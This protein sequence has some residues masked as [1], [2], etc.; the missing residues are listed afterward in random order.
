[1]GFAAYFDASGGLSDSA[2]VVAGYIARVEDWE[3]FDADWRLVLANANVPYFHMKEF[4]HFKGPYSGWQ[5]QDTRRANFLSRLVS[6]AKDHLRCRITS[7]VVTEDFNAVDR[8]YMLSEG[9]EGIHALAAKTCARKARLWL[10]ANNYHEPLKLVFE[11]GDT[12]ANQGLLRTRFKEA[13]LPVPS[14]EP[15]R[16]EHGAWL[17]PFQAADFAAWEFLKF[18]RLAERDMI[19]SLSDVR[20]SFMNLSRVPNQDG[21]YRKADLLKMCRAAGVPRREA[22]RYCSG[23]QDLGQ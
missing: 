3:R 12:D 1:M 9:V 22:R 10:E 21:I 5:G 7:I 16:N 2:K 18:T 23:G 13:G 6:V 17:T 4:A 14:F 8:D 19:R 20:K 11:D 15:K